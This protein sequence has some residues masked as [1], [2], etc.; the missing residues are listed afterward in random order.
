MS[1]NIPQHKSPFKRPSK[2]KAL[3]HWEDTIIFYKVI[4]AANDINR[5]SLD[6]IQITPDM[7]KIDADTLNQARQKHISRRQNG[8]VTTYILQVLVNKNNNVLEAGRYGTNST[9][10][11]E[12]LPSNAAGPNAT[13]KRP[14]GMKLN[15]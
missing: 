5:A 6:N 1:S 9:A 8:G 3:T 4:R 12:P 14:S 11:Q 10:L 15:G 7:V 13:P 2:R